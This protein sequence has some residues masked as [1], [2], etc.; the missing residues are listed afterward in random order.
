MHQRVLDRLQELD[1]LYPPAQPWR[2]IPGSSTRLTETARDNEARDWARVRKAMREFLDID[3]V[4]RMKAFELYDIGS[5]MRTRVALYQRDHRIGTFKST[6]FL[7]GEVKYAL[8]LQMDG[9]SE[10]DHTQPISLTNPSGESDRRITSYIKYILR[11]HGILYHCLPKTSPLILQLVI[12]Y[13][14][15]TTSPTRPMEEPKQEGWF[16][17]FLNVSKRS[18]SVPPLKTEQQ[19]SSL[20][21]ATPG[22]KGKERYLTCHMRLEFQGQSKRQILSRASSSTR[23]SGDTSITTSNAIAALSTLIEAQH[24]DFDQ[25]SRGDDAKVK[26]SKSQVRPSLSRQSTMSTRTTSSTRV[27]SSR[28]Y[29]S[30]PHPLSRQVSTDS[31]ATRR[32]L[33]DATSKVVITLS[34]PRGY[35]II[36]KALDVKLP[37]STDNNGNSVDASKSPI[38]ISRGLPMSQS[39]EQGVSRYGDVQEEEQ[40]ERGRSRSKEELR[41]LAEKIDGHVEEKMVVQGEEMDQGQ[42]R[43]RSRGRK[44]VGLLDGLFGREKALPGVGNGNRSVSTPPTMETSSLYTP[45]GM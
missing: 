36:R 35:R 27:P 18:A 26:R 6:S 3:G 41:I 13:P 17:G 11:S 24:L 32:Q 8:R 29:Y 2:A 20:P 40:V 15:T 37:D 21:G 23:S 7:K 34:D 9:D 5:E 39:P 1:R 12:P 31:T 33:Q 30:H 25:I 10:V 45:I 42:G 16:S 43:E 22:K 4:R 19:P 38:V 44:M 14:K 28:Q